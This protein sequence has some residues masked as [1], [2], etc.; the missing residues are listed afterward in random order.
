ME[1]NLKSDERDIKIPDLKDKQIQKWS[2]ECLEDQFD[3]FK[4]YSYGKQVGLTDQ[5]DKCPK[6]IQTLERFRV[7]TTLRKQI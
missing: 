6:Q 7:K 4:E 2:Q 3:W 1:K 5:L